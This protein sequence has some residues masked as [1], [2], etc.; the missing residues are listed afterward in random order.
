MYTQ[1]RRSLVSLGAN[2]LNIS[3][4]LFYVSRVN[5]I[6]NEEKAAAGELDR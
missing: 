2:A 6:C 4:P 3:H 1:L 5:S